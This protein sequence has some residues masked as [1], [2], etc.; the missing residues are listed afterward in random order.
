MGLRTALSIRQNTNTKIVFIET[1]RYPLHCRVHKL[2]IKFW[3]YVLTYIGDNL[4][5][6]LSKVVACANEIGIP[7]VRYY[8]DLLTKYSD[9]VNCGKQL[10][11]EYMDKWKQKILTAFNTDIDSKLGTYYRVNPS[12]QP[13]G[14]KDGT[15]TEN[16][17]ILLTRY[18]TGSHS[19]GVELGRFSNMSR[20]NRL[21]TCGVS[22]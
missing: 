12:L 7:Y 18:R 20:Q 6:A 4:D 9:P 1:G 8:N 15:V 11:L 21:C 2:Q 14:L 22:V 16:E 3:L 13:F 19:L 5:S 10:R 17:R